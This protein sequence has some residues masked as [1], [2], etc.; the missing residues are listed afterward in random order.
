M[1]REKY[2]T[3]V[4]VALLVIAAVVVVLV[5]GAYSDWF[6]SSFEYVFLTSNGKHLSQSNVYQFGN[7][8]FDVHQFGFKSGFKAK[9]IPVLEND[10]VFSV[11]GFFKNYQTDFANKELSAVFGLVCEKNRIKCN[12]SNLDISDI[13]QWFYPDQLVEI[14]VPPSATLLFKLVVTDLAEKHMFEL[15]FRCA[16]NVSDVTIEC[17]N[18]IF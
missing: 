6:K 16:V 11:D 3:I 14:L 2:V 1:G 10:F 5:W 13:L 12:A 17:G 15:T 4:T 18:I 7:G 8:V 9:I